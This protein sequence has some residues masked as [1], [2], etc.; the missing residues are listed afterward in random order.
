M[1]LGAGRALPHRSRPSRAAQRVMRQL[2][3]DPRSEPYSTAVVARRLWAR[4]VRSR[5]TGARRRP[6]VPALA[7][8]PAS[9]ATTAIAGILGGGLI[10]WNAAFFAQYRLGYISRTMPITFEQLTLGKLAIL[11]DLMNRFWA[12][13][14]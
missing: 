2:V 10:A 1:A 5:H 4:L 11:K 3:C 9:A 7:W 14:Q 6:D 8:I 13:I 12:L